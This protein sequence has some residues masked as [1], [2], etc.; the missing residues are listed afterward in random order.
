MSTPDNM[1]AQN[2]VAGGCNTSDTLIKPCPICGHLGKTHLLDGSIRCG[3]HRCGHV[4]FP[5]N[6]LHFFETPPPENEAATP[7]LKKFLIL[8]LKKLQRNV[9]SLVNRAVGRLEP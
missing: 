3:S 8:I 7:H 6:N 5:G 4:F 9:S 1:E 2:I